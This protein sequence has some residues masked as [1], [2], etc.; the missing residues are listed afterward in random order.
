MVL[1]VGFRLQN[2]DDFNNFDS[3]YWQ[4]KT[5]QITTNKKVPSLFFNLKQT[6]INHKKHGSM[7]KSL[8]QAGL[9][10]R[11]GVPEG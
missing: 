3:R 7:Y 6:K 5:K 9:N 1:I 10:M 8:W 11:P 4:N 2:I